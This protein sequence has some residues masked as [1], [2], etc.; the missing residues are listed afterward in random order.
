MSQELEDLVHVV[1]NRLELAGGIAAA[2]AAVRADSQQRLADLLTH[3]DF[4]EAVEWTLPYS[5]DYARK[6]AM[7]RLLEQLRAGAFAAL[8]K[9][10]VAVGFRTD[11]SSLSVLKIRAMV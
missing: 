11:N 5:S 10:P 7:A 9:R 4:L 8:G 6:D 3:P 2:A 1:D